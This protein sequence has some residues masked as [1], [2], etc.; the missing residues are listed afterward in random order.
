MINLGTYSTLANRFSG[1]ACKTIYVNNGNKSSAEITDF[2]LSFENDSVKFQYILYKSLN[3][4]IGLLI[5]TILLKAI[6]NI[7]TRIQILPYEQTVIKDG[8]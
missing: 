1:F 5:K 7:I 3:F 2:S 8:I 6:T 4:P